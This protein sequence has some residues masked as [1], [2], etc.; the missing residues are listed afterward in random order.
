MSLEKTIVADKAHESVKKKLKEALKARKKADTFRKK[1]KVESPKLEAT[2][3]ELADK[4][5]ALMSKALGL[6]VDAHASNAVAAAKQAKITLTEMDSNIKA[7]RPQYSKAGVLEHLIE[8]LD[9]QKQQLDAYVDNARAA[10]Q[11]L[12]DDEDYTGDD[13]PPPVLDAFE[14]DFV[15]N[16]TDLVDSQLGRHGAILRLDDDVQTILRNIGP[17]T[18]RILVD[19]FY[20]I[21]KYRI[22]TENQARSKWQAMDTG[23]ARVLQMFFTNFMENEDLLKAALV[24]YVKEHPVAPWLLY[25]DQIGT[26]LAAGILAH[27]NIERCP[28]AENLF[29]FAGLGCKKWEPNTRRPWNAFL[30]MHTAFKCGESFVKGPDTFYG[31]Y[32]VRRKAMEVEWND[33]GGSPKMPDKNRLA[34]V[35]A[36]TEKKMTRSGVQIGRYS[37]KTKAWLWVNGCLP[38]GSTAEIMKCKTKAEREKFVEDHR[39]DPGKGFPMLPP[40]WVHAR[41]RRWTVKLFLSHLHEVWW[42]VHFGSKP[43]A[44]C[45]I[46]GSFPEHS[47]K[48]DPPPGMDG[49]TWLR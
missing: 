21:Q 48:I 37:K 49:W 43:L 40:A 31:G 15:G 29:S 34:A 12:E 45:A 20:Q 35:E 6:E 19:L 11:V 39:M 23:D 47:H 42:W 22:S 24:H 27:V 3:K 30:K 14:T 5:V 41:A 9:R 28:Q 1:H 18:A 16:F 17:A 44:P 33:F 10:Q 4:A 26:V 13:K 8:N 46:N 25:Q 32:F 38:K 7:R 36:A 2:A